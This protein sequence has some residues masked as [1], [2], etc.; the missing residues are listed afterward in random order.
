[1]IFILF[2][3]VHRKMAEMERR[4]PIPE[5]NEDDNRPQEENSIKI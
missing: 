1:M 4:L 5:P 3:D 2:L